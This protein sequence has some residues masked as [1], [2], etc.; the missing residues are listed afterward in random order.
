MILISLEIFCDNERICPFR[1]VRFSNDK[2][3]FGPENK[4]LIKK[5]LELKFTNFHVKLGNV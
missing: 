2:A 1:S 3:S 5:L 4:K